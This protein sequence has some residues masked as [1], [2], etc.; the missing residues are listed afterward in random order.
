[1]SDVLMRVKEDTYAKY[2]MAEKTQM[3]GAYTSP[4]A[5]PLSIGPL[6]KPIRR[7]WSRESGG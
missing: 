4:H 5:L 7:A 2:S 6:D 3:V 1:M